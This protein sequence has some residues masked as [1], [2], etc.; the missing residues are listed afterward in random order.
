MT[1]GAYP[2]ELRGGLAPA[3][4]SGVS[5][6]NVIAGTEPDFCSDGCA[7]HLDQSANLLNAYGSDPSFPTAAAENC[8]L[9][10]ALELCE[11]VVSGTY[12]YTQTPQAVDLFTLIIHADDAGLPGSVIY[13]ETGIASTRVLTMDLIQGVSEVYL[14]SLT[15]SVTVI[16]P[17]GTYWF[18]VSNDTTGDTDDDWFWAAAGVDP[19]NGV[20][21]SAFANQSPGSTWSPKI[22]EY[23]MQVCGKPPEPC[24]SFCSSLP[25]QTGSAAVLTCSGDPNSS[26]VLVSSPVPNT[27]GQFFFGSMMLAGG[28]SLGDGL[29]CVGGTTTRLLPFVSAGMMMQLANTASIALNYSAPYAAGLTGTLHFQHWFR[30]GLTT[31]T[32]SNASNGISIVF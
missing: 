28:S 24:V 8:I 18:E 14:H 30:S 17:A 26:L 29:R 5:V 1:G 10:D 23:A 11:L 15:P 13:S 27:T 3:V 20:P 12:A 7:P 2:Q 9:T 16:L 19:V 25:N 32:G 31:G 6:S 22:W 4:T 21:G